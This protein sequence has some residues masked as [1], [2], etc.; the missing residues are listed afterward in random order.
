M[1]EQLCLK[2]GFIIVTESV[3]TSLGSLGYF[4]AYNYDNNGSNLTSFNNS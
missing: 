3:K 1:I 4:K 2:G